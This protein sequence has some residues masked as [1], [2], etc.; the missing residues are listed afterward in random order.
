MCPANDDIVECEQNETDFI[1]QN[2]KCAKCVF[3]EISGNQKKQSMG[4]SF[5]QQINK[6]T[7]LGLAGVRKI[8]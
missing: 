2:G 6:I 5:L 4:K 3:A 8:L 7:C 1:N